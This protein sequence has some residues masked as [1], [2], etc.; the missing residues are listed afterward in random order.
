MGLEKINEIR[1]S[2][3]ISI[4]EL[5]RLS[6]VPKSTLSKITAGITK[7]P[8]L[9]TVQSIAKALDCSLDDFDDEIDCSNKKTN[10]EHKDPIIIAASE[11][12][13]TN[14]DERINE[15]LNAKQELCSTIYA[16]NLDRRQI[17]E[18]IALVKAFENL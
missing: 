1:K 12:G 8:N 16:A 10:S 15:L 4:D 17:K 11:G 3:G 2:K 13:L 6:G 5:S 9:D 14:I 7:N 18:L